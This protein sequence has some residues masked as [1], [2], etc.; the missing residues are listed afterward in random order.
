MAEEER[1]E[2]RQEERHY[3]CNLL[4]I[5]KEAVVDAY[6][7]IGYTLFASVL[8]VLVVAPSFLFTY[9]TLQLELEMGEN[10]LNVIFNLPFVLILILYSA[11][12]FAPVNAA[13][14]SQA[15]K[16]LEGVGSLRG[17]WQNLRRNYRQTVGVYLLY[18]LAFYLFVVNIII[19]FFLLAP[20]FAKIVGLLNLYLLIFL[21]LAG[22][23]LPSLIVLQENTIKKVFKKAFL[24]A[25]ANGPLTFLA[26]AILSLIGLL[27][28]FLLPL[29]V[30][31]YGGFLQFFSVRVFLGLLEKYEAKS[32]VKMGTE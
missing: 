5:L 27:F 7:S 10:L 30:M 26:L 9:L 22:F 13:L 4:V 6:N 12:V 28:S 21:L 29:L 15:Y 18:G 1:Q 16:N 19:C 17:I 25:F 31:V 24:L 20:F 8:W 14:L 23:Y 11:L 32:T 2:E 3:T